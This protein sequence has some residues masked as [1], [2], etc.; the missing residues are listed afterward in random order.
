MSI[1]IYSY[2]N[3]FYFLFNG[4]ILIT[5]LYST[6]LQN[7]LGRMLVI[8]TDCAC[9]AKFK[10]RSISPPSLLFFGTRQNFSPGATTDVIRR[11]TFSVRRSRTT[12]REM[13]KRAKES[14][15]LNPNSKSEEWHFLSAF[16]FFSRMTDNKPFP[17]CLSLSLS[18]SHFWNE[19]WSD[20][21]VYSE[22]A[23]CLFLKRRRVENAG[24]KRWRR[25]PGNLNFS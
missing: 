22:S 23:H 19:R 1:P 16:L 8:P 3:R 13:R 2:C 9:F 6:K 12:W 10:F 15:N 24:V 7:F 11:V 21:G 25:N 18:L 14:E 17:A 20:G 4:L 5:T